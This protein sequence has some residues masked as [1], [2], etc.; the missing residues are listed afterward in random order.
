MAFLAFLFDHLKLLI[1]LL[2]YRI[3]K[4]KTWLDILILF[5]YWT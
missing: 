2:I 1:D 4:A 3:L 5:G